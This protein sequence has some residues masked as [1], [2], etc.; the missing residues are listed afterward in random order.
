MTWQAPTGRPLYDARYEENVNA[1][2]RRYGNVRKRANGPARSLI[3][4][5]ATP[6]STTQIPADD[7][8]ED[9]RRRDQE[10]GRLGLCGQ[11]HERQNAGSW[12]KR[13]LSACAL[14][15]AS[16]VR[17]G[18]RQCGQLSFWRT[19]VMT[20][21]SG[22]TG[23]TSPC[24]RKERTHAGA[25]S[26]LRTSRRVP[27][28]RGILAQASLSAARGPRQERRRVTKRCSDPSR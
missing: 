22:Q 16:I 21:P 11:W 12:G 8:N 23:A 15:G 20:L 4:R 17:E 10:G 26:P 5:T 1:A 9:Q 19:V 2:W 18:A 13:R 3:R 25:T 28:A 6:S 27:A 14:N 7:G 24:S